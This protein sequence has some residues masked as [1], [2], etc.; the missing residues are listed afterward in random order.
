[1]KV[2][3]VQCD[4][5]HQDTVTA[6]LEAVLTPIGG[7]EWVKPGMTV[8]IKA[9]LVSCMHPDKA[10]TTHPALL[11][12]LTQMLKSRG[13]HVIVGDSPGGLYNAA[14]VNRIY[15]AAGMKQVQQAGA[16]LNQNFTQRQVQNPNAKIAKDFTY[17]AWLDQAD[18]IINFCKLKT[19]GMMGMSAAA[20]NMFGTIPGTLKPEYHYRFPEIESFSDMI[21]DLDEY[22]RPVLSIVDAVIGMEGNGPTAGTPRKIGVLAASQ[23]P[24]ALDMLCAHLIGIDPHQ[25]PTL[26]AAMGRGL[27]PTSLQDI[28]VCGE[29]DSLCI[30]DFRLVT[31]SRSLQFNKESKSLI[32]RFTAKFIQTALSSRP[33]LNKSDCIGCRECEKICPAKAISMTDRKP[34]IDRSKCIR[35]F[36]CQEFCPKGAMRV[37]RTWIAR[38]LKP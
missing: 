1:M 38:L 31:G 34:V 3:I 7:L 19:H 29:Y 13:V 22:F 23:N 6:A 21:V 9:N 33:K 20:K 10:A 36:C 32:G 4:N 25:V 15:A 5:Y 8:A 12:A 27:V 37:H 35:C 30:K 24:H 17:T 26:Q 11:C 28:T 18:V 14:Y 16:E 2:S